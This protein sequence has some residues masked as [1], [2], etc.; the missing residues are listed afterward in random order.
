MKLRTMNTQEEIKA[1]LETSNTQYVKVAITDIDGVLRGKYMHVDKFL[2]SSKEGFGFCDVIFG[3]DTEDKLYEFN[4]INDDKILTGWHTGY[5]DQP[6]KIVLNSGRKIPF[7]KNTPLFLSELESGEVCPRSL[8]KK[9]LARLDKLGFKAKSAFEYEF[10]LFDETPHS[11]R[12]K[13]Y[14]NLKNFTPGMFGY[15][16]LRNSVHSELYEEVLSMCADMDMHLEGLH[17]ETGPGVIEAAIAVDEALNSADKATLFKTFMKVLAQKRGLMANF[18]AKWSEKYPGQSGHIHCSLQDKDNNPVF[19]GSDNQ[20]SE[21][22]NH[23]LGGLQKYMREFSVMFAPTVN[24]YQRLSP[25]AWAPVNMTW[26]IENRTTGFRVIEGS[27]NSCRV[28]NR[29][30]GADSNPYLA[31]AA[32]LGAG[33]LGI[34][35]KLIPSS[36]TKGGAYSLR[37]PD[38]LKVAR[39]L[40]QGAKLFKESKAAR[41]LYGDIFV[42]HFSNSREWEYN[43]FSKNKQL[44]GNGKISEWEL[45]RYFEII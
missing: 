24:S 38:E 23:F 14:T 33:L 26:G 21:I 6:A 35:E 30:P 31:L 10:F 22:M 3:W 28:E 8:L 9:I 29:L 20:N 32:T 19:S 17:T 44:I 40:K 7:E 2:K 13:K 18:M 1:Y 12:E 16:I 25:G 34:E 43:E 41:S 42:D 5:P 11:I 37:L 15:S 39:D 36:A 45:S 27:P 4:E